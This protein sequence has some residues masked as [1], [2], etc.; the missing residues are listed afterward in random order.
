MKDDE[1]IATKFYYRKITVLGAKCQRRLVIVIQ[2]N[3]M[4]FSP[5]T[6]A[7]QNIYEARRF[8]IV[9]PLRRPTQFRTSN[10]HSHIQPY[11]VRA[12]AYY[13]FIIPLAILEKS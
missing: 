7:K 12:I 1:Q 10:G 4:G 6:R 5:K 11:S 2:I 13:F 3:L 8:R 9:G